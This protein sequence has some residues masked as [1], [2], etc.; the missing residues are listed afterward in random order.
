[1]LKQISFVPYQSVGMK[2]LQK[3]VFRTSLYLICA[4]NYYANLLGDFAQALANFCANFV[5]TFY[6]Y[7]FMYSGV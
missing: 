7:G 6:I 2:L 3:N 4:F 1:M 5:S